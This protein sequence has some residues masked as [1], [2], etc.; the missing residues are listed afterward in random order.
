MKIHIRNGRLVDPKNGIDAARDVYIAEGRVVG[1]GASP[2]GF[3]ADREIDATGLRVVP[4]LVDLS[5]RL[6]E[7][8]LEYKATLDSELY[9]AVAGG[10]TSL[11]CPPATAA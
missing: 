1:V 10:V 4:G 2:G 3:T 9:A 11:A 8:G 5:A 6:R 7:P